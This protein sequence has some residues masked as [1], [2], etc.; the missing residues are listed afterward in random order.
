MQRGPTD[1]LHQDE[2]PVDEGGPRRRTLDVCPRTS[3]APPGG[4]LPRGPSNPCGGPLGGPGNLHR[5][6]D[7][8]SRAHGPL[9]G[10]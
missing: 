2:P 9:L 1:G 4:P 7:G 6:S 3:Q 10:A 8:H 5:L